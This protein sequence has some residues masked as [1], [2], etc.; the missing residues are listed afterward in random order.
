VVRLRPD[1]SDRGFSR[2]QI[3]VGTH[4]SQQ[5]VGENGEPVHIR[6]LGNLL[7]EQQ[8]RAGVR[9]VA[10]HVPGRRDPGGV[11]LPGGQDRNDPEI[12]E[13]DPTGLL[14]EQDVAGLHVPMNDSLCVGSGEGRPDL[15]HDRVRL[16]Q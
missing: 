15:R 12:G 6:T 13:K 7:V 2:G 10:D 3:P 5:L 1:V 8:L 9:Q 16:L 4:A 11:V 14:L